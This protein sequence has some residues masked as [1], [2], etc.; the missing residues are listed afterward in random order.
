MSTF[1]LWDGSRMYSKSGGAL[2]L[3]SYLRR[4][5]QLL[6]IGYIIPAPLR[7]IVYDLIASRRHRL[8][9]GFCALPTARQRQRFLS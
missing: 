8:A 5:W 4:P 6:K 1:Y 2:R 7:N 9:S 3:L